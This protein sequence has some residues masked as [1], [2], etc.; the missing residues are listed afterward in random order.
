[1]ALLWLEIDNANC[2]LDMKHLNLALVQKISLKGKEGRH[3][4]FK[5]E[6]IKT[7]YHGIKAGE[8]QVN[9]GARK[10]ELQLIPNPKM[11]KD[12]NFKDLQPSTHG[13]YIKSDYFIEVYASYDGCCANSP[14]V[15]KCI[16]IMPREV[17]FI[18][19]QEPQG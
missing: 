11:I 15:S 12:K 13:E 5:E 9:E 16:T 4:T 19:I 1:M 8:K 3:Q 6:L 18:Q 7:E 2:K 10:I 17:A 14:D